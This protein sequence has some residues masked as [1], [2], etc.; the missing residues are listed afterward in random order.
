[1]HVIILNDFGHINGGTAKVAID[2]ACEIGRR[3]IRTTYFT[4]VNPVA[5][6]LDEAG[7]HVVSTDQEELA[8]AQNKVEAVIQG[9][10]NRKAV[11]RMRALLSLCDRKKTVI[12]VHG[13]TKALSSAP[14]RVAARMGFQVVVTFHDYF[15]A[16]PNGGFFDYPLNK[17]CTLKPLSFACLARHC[18]VR[19]YSQKLYRV[20]RQVVQQHFGLLP[21]GVEHYITISEFGASVLRPFLPNEARVYRVDNPIDVERRDP[22]AVRENV[23]F[24]TVGRL[25][26]EK[27]ALLAAQAASAIGASLDILGDGVQ[28]KVI[29]A[30]ANGIRVVGWLKPEGVLA[31]LQKARA[32]VFPSLWYEV[33]PLVVL[34]ALARGVPAIVADTSAARELVENGV[35]GLWFRGGDAVDLAEK[36]K[37]IMNDDMLAAELGGAA[38]RKYWEKPRSVKSHVD[39]LLTVYRSMLDL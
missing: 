36:M 28:A 39:T 9:I 11:G 2:S 24:V 8:R 30:I 6:Q 35:T 33:Q 13:W 14:I 22:V 1:M 12:H 7:V 29:Q 18:D 16:C 27:G 19:S 3:G 25:S 21:S 32:L 38:Y 4:A 31:K 15:L 26:P 23:L 10:W 17:I 34:E 20:A 5:E 37:T